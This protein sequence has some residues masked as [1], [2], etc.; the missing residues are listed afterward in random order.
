MKTLGRYA[1]LHEGSV[2]INAMY[3]SLSGVH[4]ITL[5]DIRLSSDA[6]FT[7]PFLFI[8]GSMNITSIYLVYCAGVADIVVCFAISRVVEWY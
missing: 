5:F 8:C 7:S 6:P 2:C 1:N 4:L 3:R